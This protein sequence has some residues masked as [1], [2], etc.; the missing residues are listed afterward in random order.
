MPIAEVERSMERREYASQF[1]KNMLGKK[2]S[3]SA[4]VAGVLSGT[5][6]Q[7]LLG[8]LGTGVGATAVVVSNEIGKGAGIGVGIWVLVSA[9]ISSFVAGWVAGRVSI[10]QSKGDGM[11]HGLLT[12][13]VSTLFIMFLLGSAIGGAFGTVSRLA[14]SGLQAAASNPNMTDQAQN[15]TNT[16]QEQASNVSRQDLANASDRVAA[17]TAT[18]G[19]GL[20]LL[21]LLGGG[22][23]VA[24][25]YSATP[26]FKKM[27]APAL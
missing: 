5:F 25:G 3:W 26:K 19:F 15:V 9:L 4:I 23:A 12:A 8:S 22:A 2:I 14:G 24:G 13:A 11:L 7:L 20:F 16:L 18:A 27:N 17:G 6:I 1:M 10:S 21:L